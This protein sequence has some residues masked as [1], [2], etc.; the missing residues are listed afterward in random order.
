MQTRMV[1][2]CLTV[3]P[4]KCGS[5]ESLGDGVSI[6]RTI[7]RHYEGRLEV[8]STIDRLTF[9]WIVGAGLKVSVRKANACGVAML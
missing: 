7:T 8:L 5:I 9:I 2:C 6:S 1:T 3:G 4:Q